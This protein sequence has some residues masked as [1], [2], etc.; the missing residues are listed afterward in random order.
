MS[1]ASPFTAVTAMGSLIAPAQFARIAAGALPGQ[2][3]DDYGVPKGLTLRDELA[4]FFRIGQAQWRDFNGASEPGVGAT[5]RFVEAL[6]RDVLGFREITRHQQAVGIG[7]RSFSIALMAGPVP[8]A[9]APAVDPIDKASESVSSPG[10]RRSAATVTQ[11]FL[12]AEDAALWG[13]ATNGRSLRLVRDNPSLTRPAFIEFDLSAIFDD[14][15]YADFAAMFLT[16]HRSRFGANDGECPL[17]RWREDGAKA[18]SVAR[19]KLR[20]GVEA[21]LELLGQGFLEHPANSDLAERLRSGALP[22]TDYYAALLRLVYRLIFL[23]AAEDRNLLHPTDTANSARELYGRGYA[24]GR[25]RDRAVRRTAWDRHHDA[26]EGLR[27]VME[28]LGR[29]EPRLGLPALG[30]L[31]AAGSLPDLEAARLSNA[32]LLESVY[33]LAWLREASGPVPVNWRDMESEELGSVYEGLLELVPRLELGG[34]VFAFAKETSE[35]KGNARKTSGSYYTPDSLVQT[36]L[37][38]A[39]TPLLDA[40]VAGAEGPASALLALRVVDPACGSGHFLLAAARRI[41]ARLA[42]ARTG[43]AAAPDDYR[44][45]LRDVVGACIHGVDRN[46]MAVELTKVALWIESVEPGKPLRLLDANIRCGDAL[47]GLDDLGVLEK[48]IPDAAYAPLTGDDK[49]VA[50]TLRTINK[51]ERERP[52]LSALAYDPARLAQQAARAAALPEETLEQVNFKRRALTDAAWSPDS[53]NL[54]HAADAWVAAF[55]APKREGAVVPTTR[56]VWEATH[57]VDWRGPVI[58]EVERLATFARVFHWPLEFPAILAGGRPGFDLVIGN[59]PWEVMQLGEEEYFAARVPEIAEL[60]GAARKRAIAALEADA[61]R[62]FADYQTAKRVFDSGNVFARESGRFDLTARGKINTFGLFAETFSRLSGVGGRAGVIVPTGI[63]TDATTAPFFAHLIESKRLASLFDFENRAGIFPAV[64]SRMKFSLMTL[65]RDCPVADFAFFLTSTDQLAEPERRFTLSPAQIA[66]IN[67]NTKTAPVF[68]ARADA[69]LTAA[70]YARVPVLI[71]EAKGTVGNPWGMEFRQGLFNMTSD[72]GL[73]RTAPQ[74][75]AKGLVRDGVD[76]AAATGK[77][78]IPL[79]EAK[80]IHQFDH[81]WATYDALESR[82]VTLAEKNDPDF[83]PEPRYW[84]PQ[85]EVALRTALLPKGLLQALRAGDAELISLALA[86]TLFAKTLLATNC[87]IEGVFDAWIA[88]VERQPF[89]RGFAPTQTGLC[90][91]SPPLMGR[92]TAAQL[93][94]E[95]IDKL[96]AGPNEITSWYDIDPFRFDGL[97]ADAERWRVDLAN[98]PSLRSEAVAIAYAEVLLLAAMPRWLMGWRDIARATDKRTLISGV[99][100]PTACGDK[101]LLMMPGH[102]PQLLAALYGSLNSLP[103]DFCAR[104]KLGGTSFKYF[105]MRQIAV[106]PP[107]AYAATDLAF[108]VPRVLELTYTSHA[109]APFARDLGYTGPPYAWDEDRRA[110][111]RAELDAWYA[112]AY[113][114][115]RD[116]LRYILDPAD[117]MGPDYPSET[118][119]VLK[120]N[121]IARYGDY[122]TARLTLAAWDAQERGA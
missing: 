53:I 29:G 102:A 113:G 80:M 24:V 65:A 75:A 14:E 118:F 4:R 13:L 54:R 41:A 60:A 83:E 38:S 62:E 122:R 47:L 110:H 105:T 25:L 98:I 5:T 115:T 56:H 37:D 67:P 10:R 69:E 95:A 6:L 108:I 55:L 96:K 91:N 46:P 92:G 74:L 101:F 72:S 3:A 66:A 36:L 9:I 22:L 21:A 88:F 85:R 82:D 93:P 61:P 2:S 81:R 117:V 87:S 12:N 97:I 34:R 58:E 77:R 15:A 70:V 7:A 68:R 17:E 28:A 1:A 33:R 44:H 50:K 100:P 76:W 27:V 43:D 64:D 59:P 116:Q 31:F 89:A 48:G 71:D 39:L 119:R 32:K 42:A 111:L 20:G 49:A 73:F 79:Y 19:D 103:C 63:A 57:G 104:Q 40:T 51:A 26:W 30:G 109:M 11:E 86:H 8:V 18:G 121:D 16:L 52:I 78:Y 84:V 106:L 99:V 35:T 94:A 107:N 120:K 90:G 114:L 45:A 23:L 112:R